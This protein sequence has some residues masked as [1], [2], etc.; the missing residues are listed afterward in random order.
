MGNS[1]AVVDFYRGLGV[2]DDRLEMIY[3]G[4]ADEPPPAVDRAAVLAELGFPADAILVLFAGRLGGQKRVGD[5]LKTLDLL[6]H[7]PAQ[8][9][10]GDRRRR[11]ASGRAGG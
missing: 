6:Q 2:P 10:D 5:L 11:P 7:D 3:S 8:S 9:A 4:I 1:H